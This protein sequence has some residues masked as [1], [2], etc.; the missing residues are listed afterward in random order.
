MFRVV[1]NDKSVHHM[2]SAG[3]IKH[4]E[5]GRPLRMVGTDWM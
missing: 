5:N 2:R 4:D 3:Q 1:W